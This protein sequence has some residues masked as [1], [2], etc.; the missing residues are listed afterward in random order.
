MWNVRNLTWVSWL[1]VAVCVAAP[2]NESCISVTSK[3]RVELT[4][5]IDDSGHFC[6]G[7][8]LNQRELRDAVH[9]G[10][11]RGLPSIVYLAHSDIDL[12]LSRRTLTSLAPVT[13]YIH[14]GAQ[15]S[16][17]WP[18]RDVGQ[19]RNIR[20]R[21]GAISSTA[22]D[23]G[24]SIR[25]YGDLSGTWPYSIRSDLE[26]YT[27][28][29]FKT[30]KYDELF[31]K[32]VDKTLE[33]LRSASAHYQ[34]RGIVLENLHIRVKRYG[35][36]IEGGGTIVRNCVIEVDQ[37]AALF[38]Y[39]PQALIEN[40]V[41]IVNGIGSSLDGDAI[42]RLHGGSDSVIRNNQLVL[43]GGVSRPA[44]SLASSRNVIMENNK[45]YG[46]ENL[47]RALDDF[48][49]LVQKDNQNLPLTNWRKP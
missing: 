27:E 29:Y 47:F 41:L 17:Q 22:T 45:L 43:A 8:E 6:L 12:D 5:F 39:G 9:S 38:I 7:E 19:V 4:A 48:S 37:H 33:R 2:A 16:N 36:V 11:S 26:Q 10:E 14:A 34:S 18:Y 21:N 25:G 40:N 20:I 46:L 32:D 28:R 24:I 44:V 35:A 3:D 31:S 23:Q 15:K 42:V 13:A 30:P 1:W 49:S